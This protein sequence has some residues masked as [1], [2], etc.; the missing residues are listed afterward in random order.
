MV[1]LKGDYA[2]TVERGFDADVLQEAD[3]I[4]DIHNVR[5]IAQCHLFR[6][7]QRGTD[8][9]QSLVLRALRCDFSS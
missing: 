3:K 1:C 7:Q 2:L 6:C 4:I 9:L 5:H 8:D